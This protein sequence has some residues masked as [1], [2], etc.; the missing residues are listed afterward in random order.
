MCSSW[1]QQGRNDI[2]AAGQLIGT[3][4]NIYNCVPARTHDERFSPVSP[5]QQDDC[6]SISSVACCWVVVLDSNLLAPEWD[7]VM[8]CIGQLGWPWVACHWC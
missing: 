5:V 3:A 6:R 2:E 7:A 8:D 1:E 4:L